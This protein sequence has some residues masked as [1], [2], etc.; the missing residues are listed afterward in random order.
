MH[1]NC[2]FRFN[3]EDMQD[4]GILSKDESISVATVIASSLPCYIR[5]YLHAKYAH[6]RI[7]IPTYT[8]TYIRIH[9]YIHND[10]GVVIEKKSGDEVGDARHSTSIE[11]AIMDHFIQ[12]S[13]GMS[14]PPSPPHYPPA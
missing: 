11:T 13:N 12:K 9:T 1:S 10:R 4:E 7:H 14:Y 2:Q 5:A 8:Q 6:I 3:M